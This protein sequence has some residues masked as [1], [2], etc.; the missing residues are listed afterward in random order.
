MASQRHKAYVQGVAA[1]GKRIASHMPAFGY[2]GAYYGD[3]GNVNPN[4]ANLVSFSKT[5]PAVITLRASDMN[6]FVNGQQVVL[7]GMTGTGAATFQGN[8]YT[9]ASKNTALNQFTLTGV[10]ATALAADLTGGTATRV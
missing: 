4:V 2:A 6:D 5:N 10:N 7:A 1:D 8:P 9:L 3:G